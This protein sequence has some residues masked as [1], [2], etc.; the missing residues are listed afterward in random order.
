MLDIEDIERVHDMRV[1]TR[2]LRAAMEIFAPCFAKKQRRALLNE[3]K[4]LA[5]ALGA[6]RDADVAIV[7][8]ERVGDAMPAAD[9]PGVEHL[10]SELRD[11]QQQANDELAQALDRIEAGGLHERLLALTVERAP[12][13]AV[14]M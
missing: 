1:A 7:A 4:A 2:R 14:T 8:L 6:R 5:D 12:E 11:E 13:P 9:L 10:V 3:V